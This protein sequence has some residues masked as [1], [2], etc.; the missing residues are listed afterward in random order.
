MERFRAP[1]T[2]QWRKILFFTL[3][4][5]LNPGVCKWNVQSRQQIMDG[6]PKVITKRQVSDPCSKYPDCTSCIN[7]FDYCGW[8]SVN[9]LYN[10]TIKGTQCGGLNKTKIPGLICNGVFSTV[11]CP[12][13]TPSPSTNAPQ[14]SPPNPPTAPTP[15]P[16]L[17]ICDPKTQTCAKADNGVPGGMPLEQCKIA[18]NS[19][20]DVPVILKGR[21]FRGLE[22]NKGY[23]VG[24]WTLKF[25]N[26]SATLTDTAKT[27]LVATVFTTAQYMIL[28]LPNGKRVYSLWQIGGGSA[29]DFLSWSWGTVGGGPPK[30]FDESMIAPGQ[31]SFVFDGC[32]PNSVCKF[33]EK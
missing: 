5:C 11:D 23:I 10:G 8:C 25:D 22:I 21:F 30:S 9:V 29:L 28:D 6:F 31:K 26:K 18:C 16:V 4:K 2:T 1:G 13:D 14:T 17:Y 3:F 20:P 24:E 19:I 27:K 33:I 15:A 7:A 12:T 32:R